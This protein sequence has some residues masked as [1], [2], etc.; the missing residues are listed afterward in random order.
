MCIACVV[1]Q[2][3]LLRPVSAQPWASEDAE[4]WSLVWRQ[5]Y[6]STRTLVAAVAD[7]GGAPV[8]RSRLES[9]VGNALDAALGQLDVLARAARRAPVVLVD[10]ADPH[11]LRYRIAPGV[12]GLMSQLTD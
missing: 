1:P 3:G 6:G 10:V 4:K 12:S 7:A 9:L 8:A 5:A 2:E 11:A